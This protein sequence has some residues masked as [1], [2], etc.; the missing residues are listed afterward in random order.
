MHKIE[1]LVLI[2][3]LQVLNGCYGE[4]V[5]QFVGEA[6]GAVDKGAALSVRS[7]QVGRDSQA[8]DQ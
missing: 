3:N 5:W 4:A 7:N 8:G 2:F 6:H 1:A